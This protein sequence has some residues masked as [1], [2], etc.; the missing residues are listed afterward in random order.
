METKIEVPFYPQSFSFFI[1]MSL[2]PFKYGCKVRTGIVRV[3][4]EKL[5]VKSP[6]HFYDDY[7]VEEVYKESNKEIWALG[8]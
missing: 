5:K 6:N 3:M 2:P 1:N 8:S 4:M 7:V